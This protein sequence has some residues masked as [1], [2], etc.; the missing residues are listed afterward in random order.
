VSAAQTNT[1]TEWATPS[2]GSQPLHIFSGGGTTYYFTESARDRIASLNTSSNAITEWLLP[3]SSMP[4]SIEYSSGTV[5]L[6]AFE[7]SYVGTFNP[8]TALLSMWSVP[9]PN[10]GSIHLDL[11]STTQVYF[12]EATANKIGSLNTSTG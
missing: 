1:F 11:F 10:S 9:T 7:G 4:H 2:T 6:C 12:S 3:P 5:Y 8:S